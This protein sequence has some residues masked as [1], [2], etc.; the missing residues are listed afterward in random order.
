MGERGG[1][2]GW[3]GHDP[4]GV[5]Q[6]GFRSSESQGLMDCETREGNTYELPGSL[7]IGELH[8]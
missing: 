3:G 8:E 6:A 2:V 1:G 5:G 4:E 7:L